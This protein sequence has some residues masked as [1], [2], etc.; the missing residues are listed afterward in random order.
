[1]EINDIIKLIEVVSE[2]GLTSFVY[3]EESYKLTLKKENKTIVT[4]TM[5]PTAM[6]Y[7]AG[8]P[9]MG[10]AMASQ[11]TAPA[12]AKTEKTG[13]AAEKAAPALIGSE[14]VVKSPLVGTYFEASSKGSP[15]FVKVGDKVKKGQV[16]GI[17]EAMKLLNEIESEFDGVVEA[18]LVKDG[19]VVE[20]GQPMFRIK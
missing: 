15:A 12:A 11:P 4:N 14:K 1:M 6:S 9:D 10:A 20:Y 13:G 17:I 16:L 19:E 7:P 18:I 2:H 5:L 3:E 8:N